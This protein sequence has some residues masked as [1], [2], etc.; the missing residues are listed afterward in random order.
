MALNY[1]D[2]PKF[3]VI[4]WMHSVCLGVTKALLSFWLNSI[5]KNEDYFIGDK[6]MTI[7]YM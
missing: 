3:F 6:V 7:F 4:D 5:H 1:A 2:L